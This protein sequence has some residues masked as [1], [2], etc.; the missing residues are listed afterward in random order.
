MDNRERGPQRAEQ[1][2]RAIK[3]AATVRDDPVHSP[4][5]GF[6]CAWQGGS[7]ARESRDFTG[8][9]AAGGDLRSQR[10]ERSGIVRDHRSGCRN[11]L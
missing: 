6:E 9:G 5:K 10:A 11:L 4:L 3:F 8:M 1:W 7:L 2:K